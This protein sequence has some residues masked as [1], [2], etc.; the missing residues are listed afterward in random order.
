MSNHTLVVRLAGPLQSWGSSSRFNR[1]ATDDRPTKSGVV[2]LLAAAQGRR[3]EEPIADLVAL[4]LGVRVDQPGRL[5]RDYHTVSDFRGAP[6]PSSGLAA[7]GRPKPTSPKKLTHVTQRFYL[8]DAVF[9]VGVGGS[10]EMLLALSTA[11][12]RPAFPLALGRRACVPTQPLVVD[13]EG[14]HDLWAGGVEDVLAAVPWQAGPAARRTA[15]GPAVTLPA[16][17]DD[18]EGDDVVADVPR[19]FEP[20]RRGMRTRRVRH[21]WVTVDTGRT[22]ESRSDHDPFALLGG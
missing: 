13:S 8:Q 21:L 15:A 19:S 2:G 7:S 3:R 6:L 10:P 5:L 20:G 22:G 16:S 18:P 14:D 9:V 11:I 17:V 12:R 1:R 4:R